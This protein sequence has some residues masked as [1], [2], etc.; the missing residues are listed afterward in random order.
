MPPPSNTTTPE[1]TQTYYDDPSTNK[2]YTLLWGGQDIHIGIYPPQSPSSTTTNDPPNISTA[3]HATITHM[4]T[5]LLS[6]AIHLTPQT[7]LLDLGAGYGGS[8][9]HLAKTYGC[10]VTCL[11]LSR[12]QNARNKQLCADEGLAHNITVTEGSFEAVPSELGADFDVIWSQDSFLHSRN[13]ALVVAEID[14]LLTRRD[15]SGGG[16]VVFTDI[17]ATPDAFEKEPG[18]MKTMMERLHLE[19]L[20]TVGFY[21]REFERRGF[22]DLGFWDRK[23]HFRTHY[24]R[25]G[26]ELGRRREELVGVEG[27]EEAALERQM[28]GLGKWVEAADKGCVEWGVFCFGR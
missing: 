14:R 21:K 7:R 20:A 3:S 12:L 25:L 15:A 8:A 28:T 17:M 2:F 13:R 5:T 10:N 23:E 19:D 27:V 26:E 16:R 6:T 9:R 11:N 22:R 1:Q 24:S 18:L 4:I